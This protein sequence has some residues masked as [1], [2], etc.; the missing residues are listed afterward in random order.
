KTRSGNARVADSESE[1]VTPSQVAL[2]AVENGSDP[3]IEEEAGLEVS[4]VSDAL[5]EDSSSDELD[6]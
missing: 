3:D 6:A 4:E 5:E 2:L 1:A